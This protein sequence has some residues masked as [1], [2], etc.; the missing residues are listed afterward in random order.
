MADMLSSSLLWRALLAIGGWFSAMVHSSK[1]RVAGPYLA[2]E[3]N[4][5][6]ASPAAVRV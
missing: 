2:Y 5:R 4:A 1:V 6:M 3:Q